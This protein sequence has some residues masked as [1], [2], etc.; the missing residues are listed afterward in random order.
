MRGK[1]VVW[2]VIITNI[3]SPFWLIVEL[4]TKSLDT[5]PVI[6]LIQRIGGLVCAKEKHTWQNLL[7]FAACE[8]TAERM[9]GENV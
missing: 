5:V 6:L 2:L 9:V 8:W 1:K 3:V 7:K 4:I